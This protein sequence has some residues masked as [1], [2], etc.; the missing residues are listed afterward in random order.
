MMGAQRNAFMLT[1]ALSLAAAAGAPALADRGRDDDWNRGGEYK[2][3][4][5]DGP[6]K[7]ERRWK[8]DGSYKEKIECRR[9]SRHGHGPVVIAEPPRV[10]VQPSGPVYRPG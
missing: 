7:V 9:G 4:F 8:R 6:C 10:V 1:A 5:R 3:E 2:Q